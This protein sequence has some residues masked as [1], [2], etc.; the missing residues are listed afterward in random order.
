MIRSLKPQKQNLQTNVFAGVS[1]EIHKLLGP[2][3]CL[4]KPDLGV[5]GYDWYKQMDP[6]QEQHICLK[7]PYFEYHYC[8]VG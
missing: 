1:A 8:T 2:Y 4:Y 3:L 6:L 5:K 7:G